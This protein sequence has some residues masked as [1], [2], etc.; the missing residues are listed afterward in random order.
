MNYSSQPP[1]WTS[2]LETT[3]T[4]IMRRWETLLLFYSS[5]GGSEVRSESAISALKAV[6]RCHQWD[7]FAARFLLDRLT[8]QHILGLLEEWRAAA[9]RL[10][11][12]VCHLTSF[13][14]SWLR[15]DTREITFARRANQKIA[16]LFCVFYAQ[17]LSWVL[18]KKNA[19]SVYSSR[20]CVFLVLLC[21]WR[22]N[23][24]TVNLF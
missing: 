5:W 9:S 12:H 22:L 15:K 7:Q 10:S 13:Y 21:D 24:I 16:S 17:K 4:M 8:L 3:P 6:Y 19:Q 18:K 14:S 1:V 2:G 11:S 20:F 23:K